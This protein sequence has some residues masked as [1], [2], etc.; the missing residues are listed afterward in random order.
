MIK[1]LGYAVTFAEVPDEVSLTISVTNCGRHC[2]GCHSP[3]LQQDIGEDLE[4]DLPGLLKEFKDEITCVCFMGEGPDL[5]ALQECVDYV[6]GHGF[7]TCLYTP[8]IVNVIENLD[9]VK[10]GPYRKDVGGLG[11][12]TT[13]Q[14]MYYHGKDITER[15]W[16]PKE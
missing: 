7:K 1:Y 13:N 11:E 14:R 6:H 8:R 2:D 9:Y 5:E 3:E 12:R 4:R 15:F 10:V 16:R